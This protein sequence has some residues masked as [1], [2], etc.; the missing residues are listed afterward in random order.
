MASHSEPVVFILL[1]SEET[2]TFSCPRCYNAMGS[3]KRWKM[4]SRTLRLKVRR[5]CGPFASPTLCEAA[6]TTL[7]LTQAVLAQEAEASSVGNDLS[8]FVAPFVPRFS[9]IFPITR[10]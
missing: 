3:G 2:F 9:A 6:S 1:N 4:A 5:I 10:G 7:C 8:L